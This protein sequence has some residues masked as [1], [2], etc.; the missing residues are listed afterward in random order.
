MSK[1]KKLV[2]TALCIALGIVLP[3]LMHTIPNAGSIFLPMHLP[4]LLCGLL[5]G[6][7]YGLVCGALTPI[8]SSFI[9]GMPPMAYVAGM[10]A[11]LAVYG[12]L[13]GLLIGAIKTKKPITKIYISLVTAMI[14]GRVVYGLLNAAIFN[15]GSYSVQIWLTSL[16]ITSLPGIIIQLILIPA[17]VL[18]LKKARLAV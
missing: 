9:T 3:Q 11:E 7:S 4:V 2:Y 12:L 10:T 15:V 18:A 6:W 13:T 16:F 17:L 1:T 14:A 5:C 8:L